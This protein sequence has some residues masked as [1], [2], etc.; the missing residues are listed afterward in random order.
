M[1]G[2]VKI[3]L[4]SFDDKKIARAIGKGNKAALSKAGAFIRKDARSS[5]RRTKKSSE[6]GQPPRAHTGQLKKAILFAYDA[7]WETLVV[8]PLKARSQA[9]FIEEGTV[10]RTLEE[11]GRVRI[12]RVDPITKKKSQKRVKVA[13][14][15]FMAPAL[16]RNLK[17][18]PKQFR[19]VI[20]SG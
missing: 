20:R 16:K 9:T 4:V 12:R 19:N 6:P 3:K 2:K 18:I 13:P 1:P 11:G 7:R 14:R 5:M 10:P 8:G 17:M 15:P